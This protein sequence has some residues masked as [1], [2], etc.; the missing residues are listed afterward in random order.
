MAK[1][2]QEGGIIVKE[3]NK[4]TSVEEEKEESIETPEAPFL[5]HD[6][7]KYTK[8]EAIA[9]IMKNKDYT[10]KTQ[11][12]S[13]QKAEQEKLGKNLEEFQAMA[14]WFEDGGNQKKADQIR[15][16]IKGEEIPPPKP[17]G[18]DSDLLEGIDETDPTYKLVKGLEGKFAEMSK[19]F[20]KFQSDTGKRDVEKAQA[21]IQSEIKQAKTKY[22]FLDDEDMDDIMAIAEAQAGKNIVEV[23]DKY[24]EK[25]K[26][27]SKRE[28]D[29]L[30][31]KKEKDKEVPVEGGGIP[32][33]EP[34]RKL[35]LGDG[36]ARRSFL[37]TMNQAFKKSVKEE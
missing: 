2:D 18:A 1:Q 32:P 35:K 13:T 16:I 17:A 10:Q 9:G 14:N 7:E 24:V 23:A 29:A 6:G 30:Y 28:K 36:S 27:H 26:R 19:N 25:L 22:D 11:E 31:D 37:K 8:E 20:G 15:R 4:P 12:L 3:G 34:G 33:A 5:E 21:D